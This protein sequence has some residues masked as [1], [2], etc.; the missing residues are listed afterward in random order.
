M[1]S[2]SVGGKVRPDVEADPVMVEEVATPG[3]L[4]IDPGV[5]GAGHQTRR[6][7]TALSVFILTIWNCQVLKL[8]LLKIFLKSV[9]IIRGEGGQKET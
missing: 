8:K 1:Y 5:A 4:G 7:L 2:L 6:A 9:S 3:V